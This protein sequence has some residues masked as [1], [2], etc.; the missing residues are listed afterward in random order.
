M[1]EADI[2]KIAIR[3]IGQQYAKL[4][5]VKPQAEAAMEKSIRRI[6]QMQPIV[7]ALREGQYELPLRAS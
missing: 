7:C 5:M 1:N 6:G 3:E 4:R 2:K